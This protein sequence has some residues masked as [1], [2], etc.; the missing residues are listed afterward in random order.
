MVAPFSPNNNEHKAVLL[1][2]NCV[3]FAYGVYWTETLPP[4]FE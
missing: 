4:L 1:K 3:N 2:G